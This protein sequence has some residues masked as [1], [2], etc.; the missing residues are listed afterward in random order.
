MKRKLIAMFSCVALAAASIAGCSSS[1]PAESAAAPAETT[2]AAE[3]SEA[4]APSGD[5]KIALITMDSI[6][7][8]WVT[9]NE[10]AQKAA[11]ELGVTVTFMSP[12]TKDDAQQIE[13][14]NNAVAGGYQAIVVAANGPDAISSALKEA[15]GAGVKLVYVDS[16]ANVDAEATF[17]TDNEAAGKTAGEE[18]IKALEAAG[19]TSGK[20][21][22]VNVNAAT[23]ST[24]KREKG[25]RS[26]F[27]GKGYE[28][29]ETQYG[30]GDAA[31][32]QTIAENYITQGV[33]GIFGCNEGSTTGTGNAIKASGNANIIGVGF[34]KSDAIMNLINDGY[35][36]CTMAQNPDVMGE[37]GVKAAVAAI[38]GESLG[39][40]V[41]DTGVSVITKDGAQAGGA[42]AA[43][44]A[45]TAE[46]KAS[47][48][49][50][51][52]LITMDSIDQ[53][54]VTLNEGAQAE[55][56]KLGV[57]VTF[58]SPNTKDDAQQIECVNNAV[59]GGYQ[60]IVVAA[61][62]P[63]AIS[64]ALKEAVGAGV[65][66]VYVDSPANVDAEATFSTDNEAAG[67]TAGEEMIKALEAAGITSG[68]IGIVNVNAATD[69]TV[70]R[71]KG[72]RSAF[73]GKGYELM[74]TQ[75]GEGDA[76]KSQT[77]AENYITQ[78]VVG[79][80]GCNEGSTTGTGNAIKAS[81]NANIIGVGFDKSDA[82]M[83][84]INDG[85]L[86]CTM[87]QNPD[88]MGEDGVKAAVAALEGQDQGGKVT[89]TGVSVIKK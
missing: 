80:F 76:A 52:A 2:K 27:E 65:K 32:S 68:K 14:V 69:S 84:L 5:I 56:E 71:E 75:Y 30:E 59:A 51:I 86:L 42:P 88:V 19:I 39:G 33:V 6:D 70:K 74:E 28:L 16:P 35:L 53:H 89:D 34:D 78:G 62:G 85:Y 48:E 17:S 64:S 87:A 49:W 3:G 18:M 1:K 61:N 12:N 46:V 11:A 55:A 60:A 8:H 40:K 31:K 66:L 13:C 83:N 47:Q 44:A 63:D 57:T 37:D 4:A 41:T 79:I 58:M 36:L 67:K 15:A 43:P 10:G 9:L 22:I 20:I 82:I 29:M 25:F 45:D 73:E 50:K 21:G 23:D 72:F 24:V 54:W 7:Q 77:I 81:G 26:A 38:K